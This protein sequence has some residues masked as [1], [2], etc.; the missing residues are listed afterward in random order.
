M[1]GE[2]IVVAKKRGSA[3]CAFQIHVCSDY[4]S[5]NWIVAKK[6]LLI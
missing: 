2:Y 5:S 6:T 4:T 3:D 1:K